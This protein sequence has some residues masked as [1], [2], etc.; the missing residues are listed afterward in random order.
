M[1]SFYDFQAHHHLFLS[2]QTAF[3]LF[4]SD[5]L[6]KIRFEKRKSGF[7]DLEEDDSGPKNHEKSA[8]GLR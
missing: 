8:K 5:F 7:D 6:F 1:Y 3:S 4:E 2:H